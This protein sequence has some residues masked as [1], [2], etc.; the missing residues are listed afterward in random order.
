MDQ[1]PLGT[2]G[3]QVS[4]LGYGS[5]AIG[6]LFTKGDHAEQR[7]AIARAMEAGI[8]YYD[9]APSYGDG[10]SEENLG[11]VLRELDAGG[12]VIVGTKVRLASNDLGDPGAAIQRSIEASLRRLGHDSVDL[13]QLHNPI[14]R[15]G[16]AGGTQTASGGSVPDDL[17]RGAITEGLR[18]VQAR[19]LARHIGFTGL[20]ETEA[21]HD[22]VTSGPFA[23]M[24]SYFNAVNPSAGYA[25]ASGAEQ[26]FGGLIDAA[27]RA[28]VGVIAIRVLAAGA[29][30]AQP[31]RHANAGDPGSP[32]AGGAEYTRD[33]NRARDLE[34][35]AA[36]FELEGTLEMAVRFALAKPGIATV[37]VGYSDLSQL[38]DAI[39]WTERGPLPDEIVGRIVDAAR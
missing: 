6:G 26:D 28:N 14:V 19:G 20:G 3:L 27:A 2:T 21:L 9:T 17:V 12:R 7:R 5:G 13:L 36:E 30:A 24:Q 8:T 4:A 23:T 18:Q 16:G 15:S 32:L 22:T 37:L 35:F 39:R 10:R 25:G 31:E 29:L 34:A 33:L 1:R 11:R 38:E